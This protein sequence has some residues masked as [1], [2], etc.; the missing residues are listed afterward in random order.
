MTRVSAARSALAGA[1][2][3]LGMPA[4]AASQ[5]PSPSPRPGE[6]KMERPPAI[7]PSLRPGPIAVSRPAAISGES[8]DAGRWKG[9]RAVKTSAGE[10]DVRLADGA[11]LHLRPGDV[12][13]PDTVERIEPGRILLARRAPAAGGAGPKVATVVVSFDDAGAGRTRVYWL[14]DPKAIAPPVVK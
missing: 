5:T 14:A 3:A 9:V 13:G 8:S 4:W 11:S 6:V 12:V 10:A 2:L 1:A 7:A